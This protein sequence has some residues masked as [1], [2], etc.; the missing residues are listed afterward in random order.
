MTQLRL[1]VVTYLCGSYARSTL[2]RIGAGEV[3]HRTSA[4]MLEQDS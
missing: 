1:P 4:D 3:I 2:D